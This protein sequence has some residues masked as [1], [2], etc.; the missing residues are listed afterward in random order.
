MSEPTT[1]FEEP[2]PNYTTPQS[3]ALMA[4]ESWG[5]T[6]FEYY[7]KANRREMAE[8]LERVEWQAVEADTER[9]SAW[10]REDVEKRVDEIRREAAEAAL[11]QLAT[12]VEALRKLHDQ[13]NAEQDIPCV[14]VS[15]GCR[16]AIILAN[17]STAATEH[18]E[19]IRRDGATTER[20]RLLALF[21][22]GWRRETG[23]PNPDGETAAIG[24]AIRRVRDRLTGHREDDPECDCYECRSIA[25]EDM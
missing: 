13:V 18:D 16:P 23:D 22:L 8:A 14:G 20:E 11:S 12:V 3:K 6:G 25:A 17:L 19:R 10:I 15:G 24:Y 5:R 21:D 4:N 1:E 2:W 7:H 9:C